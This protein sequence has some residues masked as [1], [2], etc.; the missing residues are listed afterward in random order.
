MLAV[1]VGLSAGEHGDID[2]EGKVRLSLVVGAKEMRLRRVK[3][4]REKK[5]DWIRRFRLLQNGP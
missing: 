5:W 3:L 4:S 2:C 1:V